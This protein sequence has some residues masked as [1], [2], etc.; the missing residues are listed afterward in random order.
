MSWLPKIQSARWIWIAF[1]F[2][3]ILVLAAMLWL[4][5]S[6][7]STEQDRSNAEIRAE[8]QERVRLTLWRMDSLGTSILLQENLIPA[9]LFLENPQS[10]L[11]VTARFESADG[12][13]I[14]GEGDATALDFIGS[15]LPKLAT[16]YVT[17][18]Q[19]NIKKETQEITPAEKPIPNLKVWR[20]SKAQDTANLVEKKKRFEQL[21][22]AVAVQ[23]QNKAVLIP[24]APTAMAADTMD[25]GGSSL[26]ED[27]PLENENPVGNFK[28][29]RFEDS[30]FLI[31]QGAGNRKFLQ[32]SLINQPAMME[33]LLGEATTLLPEAKLAPA[34]NSSGDPFV[35]ASF[36]FKLIPGTLGI[37][38][39]S[40]PR[41][42]STSL[43]VGWL[44]AMIALLTAFFLISSIMAL[45]E[46][47]ASFVSAVTHELR[48][49]LTTFR[50]YSDMLNQGA[51]KEE[52]KH[53]Y[54][55]VLSREA[56]RLSHLVENVL[57]FSKIERGS[58]RS[59]LVQ[60]NLNELLESFHERFSSR[61][62]A[63][64]LTLV[65][66]LAAPVQLNLD[67]SALEHILFNLIDNAAKY[68]T[69]S[70][71]T[72]VCLSTQ[73]SEKH[74]SIEIADHGPGISKEECSRVFK[75]F[76]KSAKQAAET[77]PGVGLGLALSTRLAHSM[78]GKLSCTP[79][80]DGKSG[81][82]FIL[83]LPHS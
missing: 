46:R 69:N 5:K 42:I 67:S 8:L 50:L 76:H 38:P 60:V 37:T 17:S 39:D 22:R 2:C 35:L 47:R 64:E 43:A 24:A 34:T 65:Y 82:V 3:A 16:S 25:I 31:R 15:I 57:S 23:R 70:S 26:K 53:I 61:L 6:V 30:L 66:K 54:L 32:G 21:D 55:N 56:D 51:V 81:T 77:K 29:T 7:I 41:T 80:K 1:S 36:S 52:K 18:R 13:A 4:T 40:I 78:R 28:P 68:A 74:L 59:N 44:A 75:P 72:T 12:T 45:S 9:G 14:R 71:P 20:S 11:P 73:I 10:E 63:A 48:T 27:A 62:K 19:Q 58:A 49:P 33:L 79:R 83:S